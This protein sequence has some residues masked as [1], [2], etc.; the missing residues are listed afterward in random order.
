MDTTAAQPTIVETDIVCRRCG[1]NLR[2]LAET[3]SCPEC[4]SPVRRS[5]EGDLLRNGDPAWVST[6]ANGA[7]LVVV[8]TVPLIVGMVLLGLWRTPR[9]WVVVGLAL[10]GVVTAIGLWKLTVL[11]P[12]IVEQRERTIARRLVRVCMAG[13]IL[14]P[15]G[16]VL[17]SRLPWTA[18]MG[19]I[20]ITIAVGVTCIAAFFRHLQ[21]LGR[22]IPD[23]ALVLESG[24]VLWGMAISY[25]VAT[26]LA[27]AALAPGSLPRPLGM[28]F[29]F[30][31]TFIIGVQI[32]TIWTVAL[33]AKYRVR[34]HAA[35]LESQET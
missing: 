31:C 15:A 21:H 6:L 32:F 19:Y 16:L 28:I 9:P 12:S 4:D 14:L 2:G 18:R 17:A 23:D 7:T 1:Y 24:I 27:L 13:M 22:R 29:G 3:G 33:I 34:L 35:A 25:A 26:A 20:A 11:D 5:L 10:A 8:G 30:S